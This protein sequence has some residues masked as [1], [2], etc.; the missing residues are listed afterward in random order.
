MS[1]VWLSSQCS[2]STTCFSTRRPWT[3]NAARSQFQLRRTLTTRASA[4][5]PRRSASPSPLA[6][7]ASPRPP[8]A[9]L[10]NERWAS[11]RT[12]RQS[13]RSTS[14]VRSQW[15][16]LRAAAHWCLDLMM[17]AQRAALHVRTS[18][19]RR[20]TNCTAELTVRKLIVEDFCS[21]E[22]VYIT[23]NCA[24]IERITQSKTRFF[25]DF[26]WRGYPPFVGKCL[27]FCLKF[28]GVIIIWRVYTLYSDDS[29]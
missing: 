13:S 6:N 8:P 28:G 16:A 23:D 7:E 29:Y 4:S 22:F 5:R 15:R 24:N 9:R 1:S 21:Y 17:T 2:H 18:A 10:S 14:A 19:G 26:W 3:P 11:T 27:I 20:C 25:E 12:R